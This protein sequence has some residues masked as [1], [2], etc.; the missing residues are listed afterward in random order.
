MARKIFLFLLAAFCGVSLS[1][2]QGGNPNPNSPNNPR[3]V[4]FPKP[5]YPTEAK[6]AKA[7]GRVEVSVTVDEKGNVITATAV[8]GHF[9]LRKA[10]VQA[11][12]KA[13]F[14][15]N[16]LAGKPVKTFTVLTYN[17][18]NFNLTDNYSYPSKI[19]DFADVKRENQEY[20]AILNLVENYKVA[21]GYA[22]GNFHSEMPLTRADFAQFLRQTL[23]FLSARA[24]LANKNPRQLNLFS[25]HN[26]HNVVSIE[27]IKD[28]KKN[29]PFSDS[30][31][32]LLEKYKIALVNN[33]HEFRPSQYLTQ[34]ELIDVWT[35]IFG[36]EAIPVNFQKTKNF[37]RTLS[38]GNFAIFLYESLGVLTYKVLP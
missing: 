11:A 10:A 7:A 34:N 30:V 1:F 24:K 3:L 38:R 9:L 23:D 31:K 5:K 12:L 29:Q 26:P 4:S 35:R 15:P 17:F 27:K 16:S 13:K 32:T 2:A 25:P 6:A 28:F 33:L 18:D 14:A 8:S 20:E 22:E 19:E 21:F 36:E 37:E